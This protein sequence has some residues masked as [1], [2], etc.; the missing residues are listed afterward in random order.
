M[1]QSAKF[2]IRC[3]HSLVKVFADEEL[4]EPSFEEGTALL[5]EYYSFQ[6]AC[7]AAYLMKNIR[8]TAESDLGEAISIRSVGLAPSELTNYNDYDDYLLRTTPGL[9]PDPLYPLLDGGT[10]HALP[11]QWRSVWVTVKL[12]ADTAA[13]VH[14]IVIR[15]AEESGT[16][17]GEATFRLDVIGAA[18]P[19]QKL[20]HTEWFYLDC[21]ATQYGVDIFSEEHWRIVETYVD[22]Y[23][24]YGMNLILTPLFS[25]PLELD[26]GKYRPTVQMVGVERNDGRY[27]FDFS[28]LARWVELCRR[29]GI[30]R[31]EF[32]HLFTQ[33]G[34]RHAPKIMAV[35]NGVEEQ[36]FGWETDAAGDEYRSFLTQFMPELM[37]FIR[38][39]GLEQSCFFHLSD[40]PS[41]HDLESYT[42]ASTLVRSLFEGSEFP[43][44]DALSEFAFY[45]KGLLTHPVVSIEHIHHYIA[46]KADPLW[47][48]Y[49]CCEYKHGE[50]N[51]FFNMPS[52]RNRI[53]G[54]Q[55]YKYDMQGFL[56]WGYNHWYSQ[57][58]RRAIDPFTVT[59]ADHAFPS[60]D[61]FLV[62][63]GESGPITSI[64]L[65]VLREALQDIRALQLLEGYIGKEATVAL[66][67]E[68][69]VEPVT[70][71]NYEKGSDW[72]TGMRERVN[73]RIHACLQ[74]ETVC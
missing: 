52:A 55:M 34:A 72:I 45:E 10:V 59:D 64:R 16:L 9:Y 11:E 61:A 5:G 30:E 46:G 29:N 7:R 70:F 13:G 3:L 2:D 40:E 31:F 57:R 71:R 58:S 33:W 15:F 1:T 39:H 22:H 25:P 66:L 17:L 74:G 50:S 49:C 63:P 44:I 68:G 32:S 51:R 8:V 41:L 38:Q 19:E 69:M 56:H 35:E 24:E 47:A 28:R 60:G 27:A 62:Y 43:I 23:A 37:Q 67:E 20:L 18:L 53:I 65:E 6:V 4:R 14:P 12:Q 21:L 42:S 36:I 73:R 48:Y 26:Y 54:V